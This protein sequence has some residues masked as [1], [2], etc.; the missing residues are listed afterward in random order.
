MGIAN[1]SNY[2]DGRCAPLIHIR[3]RMNKLLHVI[4]REAY[5]IVENMIMRRPCCPNHPSMCTHVEVKVP[6]MAHFAVHNST[7]RNVIWRSSLKKLGMMVLLSYNHSELGRPLLIE[8]LAC[9]NDLIE[10]NVYDLGKLAFT[11]SIPKTSK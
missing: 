8:K 10:F 4:S 1:W 2:G 3:E 6:R 11:N 7:R 9:L 5:L